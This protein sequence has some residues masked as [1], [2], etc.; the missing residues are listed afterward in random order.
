MNECEE[1][2]DV[3]EVCTAVVGRGKTVSGTGGK[4]FNWASESSKSLFLLFP[5]NDSALA[6]ASSVISFN[7]SFVTGSFNCFLWKNGCF[8]FTEI[9]RMSF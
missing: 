5:S 6:I 7:L 4:F 8:T 3:D 1:V 2:N 9:N